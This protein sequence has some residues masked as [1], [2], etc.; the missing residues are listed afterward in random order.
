MDPYTCTCWLL[1]TPTG[2]APFADLEVHRRVRVRF[3]D[4]RLAEGA[5]GL[6]YQQTGD[7]RYERVLE[8]EDGDTVALSRFADVAQVEILSSTVSTRDLAQM[9]AEWIEKPS[10]IPLGDEVYYDVPIGSHEW[11]EVTIKRSRI[12]CGPE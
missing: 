6:A 12:A 10:T 3:S 7:G 5:L 1:P 11:L 2:V 4:G 9:A 8:V